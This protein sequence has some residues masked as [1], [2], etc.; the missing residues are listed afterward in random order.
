MSFMTGFQIFSALICLLTGCGQAPAKPGTQ[1]KVEATGTPDPALTPEPEAS[2]APDPAPSASPVP[3]APATF[4]LTAY[5]LTKTRS[6]V[7]G[8]VTKTYV[9]TG[10]CVQYLGK[11]YCWDDGVK[12]IPAWTLNSSSFG[13]FSYTYFG[14]DSTPSVPFQ[15]CL[16]FCTTDPMVRPV[17]VRA[18]VLGVITQAAVDEIFHSGVETTVNCTDDGDRLD[19]IDFVIDLNQAIL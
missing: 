11:T 9:S 16:G 10:S 2:S 4:P 18:P 3:A 6:P 13:P 12:V 1:A 5:K 14:A 17:T 7:T 19:C 8:W 15:S